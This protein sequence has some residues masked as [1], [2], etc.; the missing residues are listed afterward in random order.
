MHR[1]LLAALTLGAAL[2]AA[3]QSDFPN[4]PITMLVGFAPGGAADVTARVVAKKLAE[5]LGQPVT[6]ENKGGAGGNTVH[7]Q[8]STTAPDGYTILLGSVG[9]LAI[10]PH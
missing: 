1:T 4:R 2:H 10:S 6:V 5:N 9:P 8:L 3:A 7:Q